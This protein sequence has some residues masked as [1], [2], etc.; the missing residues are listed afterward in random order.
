MRKITILHISDLHKEKKASYNSL[1]QTLV[2]EYESFKAEEIPMPNYIVVSGD[3]VQ[4]GETDAEIVQ[5]YKDTASFLNQLCELFLGND[6]RKL[7]MVPGNH[8]VNWVTTKEVIKPSAMKDMEAAYK[9]YEGHNTDLRWSWD[10]H[11]YYRITDLSKY[12]HRFDLFIDFYNTFYEG[13]YT[14]PDDPEK[15]AKF[16]P[17]EDDGIA[18][19]CFNSC[20]NTDHLNVAGDIDEDSISSIAEE[21]RESYNRGWL[22]IGVW[23]HHYYGN[24][25]ETNYLSRYL[26]T[27]MLEYNI[28][29][30][31][32]GHQHL[33]KVAEEYTD[34]SYEDEE[35]HLQK[36]ILLISSGTL[37]GGGKQLPYGQKRQYNIIEID[38]DNGYADVSINIREDVNPNANSKIPIWMCKNIKYNRDNKIHNRVYFK[39][40]DESDVI[41]TID[42][43]T[44]RTGKYDE[45][46]LRLEPLLQNERA[47]SLY[48]D[49]VEILQSKQNAK[50]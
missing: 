12:N 22:N 7:I 24:P 31:L 43:D 28:K 48:N 14:Y 30:G 37:F 1:F 13:I 6:K 19:A 45:G 41:M 36:R 33:S 46:L 42:R 15:R 26:F 23:H 8:D 5:Q 9:E 49:Y 35:L 39:K 34:L 38:M 11:A 16:I 18:F 40:L 47:Q 29:I 10:D 17:F 20:C 2:K 32:F 44:R 4:G 3:L 21:L 27:D 50:G 25:Y